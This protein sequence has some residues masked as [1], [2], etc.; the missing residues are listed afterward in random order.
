[1]GDFNFCSTS[2]E[3]KTYEQIFSQYIDAWTELKPDDLK[4]SATIGT[5]YPNPE[6]SPARFDRICYKSNCC[7]SLDIKLIGRNKKSEGFKVFPSDHSGVLAKIKIMNSSIMKKYEK[8]TA[9][10]SKIFS[11]S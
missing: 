7:Y 11:R 8:T 10:I 4:Q 9:G 1:M 2:S 3:Q 6:Y 5:N